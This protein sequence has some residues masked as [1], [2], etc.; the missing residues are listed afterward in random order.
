MN[1]RPTARLIVLCVLSALAACDRDKPAASSDPSAPS[2]TSSAYNDAAGPPSPEQ[3]KTL[4]RL[5]ERGEAKACGDQSVLNYIM[6]EAVAANRFLE[7]AGWTATSR[8][9]FYATYTSDVRGIVLNA[10]DKVAKSVSCGATYFEVSA[11]QQFWQDIQY[12]LQVTVDGGVVTRIHDRAALQRVSLAAVEHYN[13]MVVYPRYQRQYLEAARQKASATA[14]PTVN[15]PAPQADRSLSPTTASGTAADRDVV[16]GTASAAPAVITGPPPE[17]AP[18]RAPPRPQVI[19]NPAWAR[20]PQAQFP[21]AARDRGIAS[22]TAT[23]LCSVRANGSLSSCQIVS[24][25][26]SG[27]GFGQAA[28]QAAASARV[29]P[30]AVDGLAPGGS[31]RFTVPFSDD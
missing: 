14:R 4:A 1:L 22:A 30:R 16:E 15:L 7:A 12:D 20:A 19:N 8:A 29:T 26:H 17:P 6:N 11:Q 9:E 13:T 3:I 27:F 21:D 10:H 18:E 2:P 24:E 31:V 28:A 5:V 23:L 25:T